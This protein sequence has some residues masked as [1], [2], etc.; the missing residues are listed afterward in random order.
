[1]S[2]NNIKSGI[3]YGLSAY[4]LWGFLPIYWKFLENVDAGAVLAHRIIWS[5]VFMISFILITKRWSLFIQQCK[6]IVT[7]KKVLITITIASILISFNWLIFIWAV[8]NGYVVQS[9]LGYYINPLISVLFAIVFLQEKLSQLQILSL[10]LAGIG[11]VYL[12]IDY[13]V[14][15]WISFILAITFASYGL[16]KKIANVDATFGLAIE[17][18]V[19]TPIALVYLW[20]TFGANMGFQD[21]SFTEILLLVFSGAATAI[22][23]LL[24]GMAVITI[25]LSMIGFL[26]YIAPTIMLLIGVLLYKEAFTSAHAITFGFIWLSL[27]LYM[28]SSLRNQRKRRMG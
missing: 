14:F 1:M 17:T 20:F 15:P 8:Q 13:G 26:Q 12:T 23:L 4:L 21:T 3:I 18:L 9:S 7:N 27:V 10:V 2:N 16:L 25:P 6:N 19:V 22:P 24:F 28:Y 5:F 11:V